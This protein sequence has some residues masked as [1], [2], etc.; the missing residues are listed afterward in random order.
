[1][2]EKAA[3]I[4]QQVWR[5][6][7]L[8]SCEGQCKS[9]YH[10]GERVLLP[11]TE[12]QN[13]EC[14]ECFCIRRKREILDADNVSKRKRYDTPVPAGIARCRTGPHMVPLRCVLSSCRPWYDIQRSNGT[15]ATT[16]LS[17]SFRRLHYIAT[18]TWQ[19]T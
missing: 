12:L 3:T 17:P 18:Q 2:E 9:K 16:M 11:N 6:Y 8:Y 1:M 10:K 7:F 4:I 13:G 15:I 14:F 5:S 19:N